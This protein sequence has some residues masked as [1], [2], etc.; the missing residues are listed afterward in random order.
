[1]PEKIYYK[2]GDGV[3]I[4]GDWYTSPT[5][6][7]GMLLL[8]MMR[9]SRSSW[10]ALQRS[11]AKLGIA[12]LSIDL[13]GHGESIKGWNEAIMDYRQFVDAQHQESITD[14]MA[15][16]DWIKGRGMGSERIAVG[17]ASFGANL[18]LWLMNESP[19]L[20]CGVVLS[21]GANYRGTDAVGFAKNLLVS[22]SVFMAASD[23]DKESFLD[24]KK[25]FDAAYCEKKVFM[26]YK[27]AGHGTDILKKDPIL[28]DKIADWVWN[29]FRG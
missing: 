21:A 23:E 5:M 19:S 12:S 15:G 11:L 10:A 22:Q 14:A 9:E 1:M 16:I 28:N 24:T 4:V 3:T 13:R 6:I 27:G 26:P 18:A 29:I 20:S 8:P 7:G 17:G 25:A 2:T